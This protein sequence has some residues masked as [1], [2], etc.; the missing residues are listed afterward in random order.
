VFHKPDLKVRIGIMEKDNPIPLCYC[1]DYSRQDVR[2]DIETAGKTTILEEIK[3]EVQGGFCTCEV[4][5]PSGACCLGEITCAIQEVKK[6][7][8]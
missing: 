4:K 2:R 6:D 1:F 3:V 5:K 7:A 8:T